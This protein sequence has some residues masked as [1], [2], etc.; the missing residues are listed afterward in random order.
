M[1]EESENQETT[2]EE[3]LNFEEEKI[4]AYSFRLF[5]DFL[6][7]SHS[8]EY[9]KIYS[10]PFVKSIVEDDVEPCL[11]FRTIT[12]VLSKK[13]FESICNH[14][15]RIKNDSSIY[16]SSSTTNSTDNSLPRQKAPNI[17]ES[18]QNSQTGFFTSFSNSFTSLMPHQKLITTS[19]T[20]CSKTIVPKNHFILSNSPESTE[21]P[22][23]YF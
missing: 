17:L 19:C 8:A 11:R 1:I 10:L 6:V 20:T 18:S 5:T 3:L 13:L 12:N 14:T 9:E 2:T 7:S 23:W 21:Y 15:C 22:I 4:E 16:Q